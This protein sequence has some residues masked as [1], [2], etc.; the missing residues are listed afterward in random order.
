MKTIIFIIALFF[1]YGCKSKNP[2]EPPPVPQNIIELKLNNFWEYR[3]EYFSSNGDITRIDTFK[4]TITKDTVI[5]SSVWFYNDYYWIYQSNLS[6]GFYIYVNNIPTIIWKYP[7]T[8]GDVYYRASD[9]VEVMS[10]NKVTSIG[11]INY[12]CYQYQSIF[13][14]LPINTYASPGLGIVYSEGAVS[15]NNGE[16]YINS[17]VYLINYKIN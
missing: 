8:K 7:A 6:D 9:T 14:G 10:T 16:P 1:L 15:I 5:N 4:V 3:R 17:K 13:R 2:V 12:N 11:N